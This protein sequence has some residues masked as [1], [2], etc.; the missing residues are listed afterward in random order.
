MKNSIESGWSSEETLYV[1]FF[2]G[3]ICC[4]K[5]KTIDKIPHPPYVKVSTVGDVMRSV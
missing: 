4:L 2:E 5:E 3:F 1:L